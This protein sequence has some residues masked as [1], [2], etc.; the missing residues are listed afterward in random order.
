MAKKLKVRLNNKLNK[1][2]HCTVAIKFYSIFVTELAF[3]FFV[4][5]YP[6]HCEFPKN[7]QRSRRLKILEIPGGSGGLHRP[8]GTENP[9]GWG[10]QMKESFVGDGGGGMNIFWDC[11]IWLSHKV[12]SKRR[13]N[14]LALIV[15]TNS[16]NEGRNT[17][18][19]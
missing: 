11:T 4:L 17:N 3:N 6:N 1:R 13:R 15:I 16:Y 12:E 2:L 14:M 9:G 18:L 19:S 7:G 5:K 8:P 10:M